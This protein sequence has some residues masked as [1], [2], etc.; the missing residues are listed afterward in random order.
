MTSMGPKRLPAF[1]P[2]P[3]YKFQVAE[4]HDDAG[5]AVTLSRIN[6][7]AY[8]CVKRGSKAIEPKI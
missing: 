7:G 1:R 8:S 4:F 3:Q 6:E 5:A 2:D